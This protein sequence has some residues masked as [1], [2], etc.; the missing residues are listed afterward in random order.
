MYIPAHFRE[1][2][3]EI[4]H[5]AIREIGF[6]TLITQGGDGVEANHLPM[7]LEEGALKGHFARANPVWKSLDPGK[8]ALA[9]FLG[10]NFYVT[11]SWYATKAETGKVVPTWNYLTVHAYGRLS[12]FDEEARLRSLVDGLTRRHES[13]R[14]LPWS[15]NDAPSGFID[16]QLRAIIGFEIAITR[17]DGKW[18]MSQN[19]V[20]ADRQGV[21]DGLTD[22]GDEALASLIP[23]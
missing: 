19:R 2:R 10:P 7:L 14:E 5:Q 16:S 13:G 15:L 6:A 11:P 17:M 22:Q 21:R 18:K 1:D 9:I 4:L 20:I 3:P 12:L 23:Q 8:E